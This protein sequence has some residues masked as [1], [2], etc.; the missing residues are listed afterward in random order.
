LFLLIALSMPVCLLVYHL[1]LWSTEQ[2]AIASGSQA[3]FEWAGLIGLAAQGIIMTGITVALWRFTTDL[4]FKAVYAGWLGAALMAFPGL[5]LRLLG[6]NNDQLGSILQILICIVAAVIVIRI[7]GKRI[8]WK[9][10]N[11]SL[12]FLLAAFGVGPFAVLGAFG[13]PPDAIL[14]LLAG[15]SFGWL[16]AL[17]MESTTENRFLDAFGSGAVLALLG[18]AI[19]YDGGQLILLAILPSFAFAIAALMPSRISAAILTGLLTAA[20]LIFFDPTELTIVLGDLFG[21]ASW[22]LDSRRLWVVC[23]LVALI[24]L[25]PYQCR[26]RV[27]V[28]RV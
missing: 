15:L 23:G 16:A 6:P 5:L 11:I 28:M 24:I 13:S 7:W 17:L 21:I 26:C 19:G 2:T 9:S 20:G 3:Q 12:A 22:Q 4:R 18:S 25:D 10:N 14:S 8:D 1:V 27:S